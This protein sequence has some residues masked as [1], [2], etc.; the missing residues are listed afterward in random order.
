[1]ESS[2][3]QYAV[4]MNNITKNFGTFCA[5]NNVNLQV[6]KGTIHSLL[7][8]N[9]AGKSTLMNILYGLYKAN[10]G[11]IYINGQRVDIKNPAAAIALGIGMVHQHFMLVE[12]FT[13]VQNIILGDERTGSTGVLDIHEATQRVM[14]LSERYGLSIEPDALIED[15]SV[16]MQQR[17]E[18]LKA[19]YRGVDILILDEPTAVLTPQEITELIAIMRR[20]TED[21]KT[22]IIITH[23]LGEI[24]R[25]A[26]YCTV[27]RRGQYIDT[28]D[29]KSAKESYL[30]SLMVGRDVNLHVAK[31]AG[32]PG[33]VVLEIKDLHVND[34]R[35]IEKVKGFDLSV[36]RG[37]IVGIA[38]IDGNGQTELVE[39]IMSIRKSQSGQILLGGKDIANTSPRNILASGLSCIPE[40]RQKQGLVMQF[41]VSE[42]MVLERY[43]QAPFSNMGILNLHKIESFANDLIERF[44]VR[45]SGS[46]KHVTCSL[47]GGN[48]QKVIL[49]REIT[50]NPD[51][52]VAVQPTRGLDVGAIEYVHKALV[53]QR[54]HGKAVLLISLELD[55]VM[56]V[57][58]RIAVIYDGKIVAELDAAT[59]DEN[60]IGLLMAGG[61]LND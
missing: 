28:V 20:L 26:D 1:M 39:A 53:E 34:I 30:A 50:N 61:A 9:G 32:T 15:I 40:D 22:V 17:V 36:R 55:E 14:Q 41:T 52:L 57:S 38:G 33:E 48:Q 18:I 51:L 11:D 5:L 37:E 24:K 7:G 46:A 27:I 49:A 4:E 13:V 12:P 45:P 8:E 25:S 60:Q 21:G 35:G 58:D 2:S 54:N 43:R 44:D 6:R 47:S 19:L 31:E 56:D 59:A 29:V 10:Q 42:N 16:G 23:K 3:L